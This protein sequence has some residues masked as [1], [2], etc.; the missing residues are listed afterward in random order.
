MRCND[1]DERPDGLRSIGGQRPLGLQVEHAD[2]GAPRPQR[3]RELRNDARERGDVVGVVAH[4]HDQLGAPE[5][6]RAAGDAALGRDPLRNDRVAALRDEP[7]PS[8]LEH[9]DRCQQSR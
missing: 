6:D 3:H 9:E 7:E 8:V 1:P 2:D 5:P 4:V